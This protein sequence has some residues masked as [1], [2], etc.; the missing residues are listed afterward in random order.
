MWARG[1]EL[2]F[3]CLPFVCPLSAC[4]NERWNKNVTHAERAAQPFIA[5]QQTN[6]W[7]ANRREIVWCFANIWPCYCS[8]R[9]LSSPLRC[10]GAFPEKVT[11]SCLIAATPPQFSC[12][13]SNWHMVQTVHKHGGRV[14]MFWVFHF[15]PPQLWFCLHTTAFSE[16]DYRHAGVFFCA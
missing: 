7:H 11:G 15:S 4:R 5:C 16:R 14:R 9:S 3:A 8:K 6:I 2:V 1:N 13:H 12:G 10:T